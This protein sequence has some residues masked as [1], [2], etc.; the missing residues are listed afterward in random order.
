[1]E[2][3]LTF[4]E[5]RLGMQ[6]A[7]ARADAGGRWGLRVTSTASCPSTVTEGDEVVGVNGVPLHSFRAETCL[8]ILACSFNRRVRFRRPAVIGESGDAP[9]DTGGKEEDAGAF[10]PATHD[11]EADLPAEGPSGIFTVELA[12]G[13]TREA[14]ALRHAAATAARGCGGLLVDSRH[15]ALADAGLEPGD[16]ILS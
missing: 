4:A 5:G 9:D 11:S 8:K 6:V 14:L 10:S 13:D 7:P 2:Y 1:M 3:E 16:V 12:D 15:A